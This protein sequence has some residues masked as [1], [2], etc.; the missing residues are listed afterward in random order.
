MASPCRIPGPVLRGC[1]SQAC[2]RDTLPDE[3]Q[4]SAS[5]C[6]RSADRSA[7]TSG[8]ERPHQQFH[9]FSRRQDRWQSVSSPPPS[10]LGRSSFPGRK[11]PTHIKG[12]CRGTGPNMW[13]HHHSVDA[14]SCRL[15]P[16]AVQAKSSS[17]SYTSS[18]TS[19]AAA[20]NPT[21]PS[22]IPLFEE[23][24]LDHPAWAGRTFSRATNIALAL[25]P[26]FHA[27]RDAAR[28]YF[29]RFAEE[30]GIPWREL[31]SSLEQSTVYDEMDLVENK[32]ITY[33]EYYLKPFHGYKESNLCWKAAFEIEPANLM[34]AKRAFK[35]VMPTTSPIECEELQKR[36]WI[37]AV[38]NHLDRYGPKGPVTDI[39]DIGCSIGL[40][41]NALADAF[42]DAQVTGLDASPHFLAVAS[43]RQKQAAQA[44]KARSKPIRW[45]HALAED[46]GLP[47]RSFDIVS[48]SY[49]VHE[50][51]LHIKQSIFSEARRLLRPGGT[52]A[53]IDISPK[54]KH[55]HQIP[56]PIAVLIKSMEPFLD[57]HFLFDCK[58]ELQKAGFTNVESVLTNPRHA[59]TTA[60]AA[61]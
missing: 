35:T 23:A 31:V 17:S 14:N 42:P 56:L 58:S 20:D 30:S 22:Q 38:K 29:M 8:C 24:D 11:V 32:S 36:Y 50:L 12:T 28:G 41:A 54:S 7:P 37:L 47:S 26:I 9:Q 45:M 34:V 13:F 51:P 48:L 10:L 25:S 60:T 46:S 21:I 3:A 59:T 33:P 55:Y 15:R 43:Y 6:S 40:S 5:T 61:A 27:V 44:G 53:I 18:P 52:I 19:T 16:S 39:L 1:N 2:G 4:C 57:E 49:V